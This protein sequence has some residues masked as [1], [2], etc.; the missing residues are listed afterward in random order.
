MRRT[1]FREESLGSEEEGG[2]CAQYFI[3]LN[4]NPRR[5]RLTSPPGQHSLRGPWRVYRAPLS[6]KGHEQDGRGMG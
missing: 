5:R 1:A 3:K 2:G 4:V 6:L